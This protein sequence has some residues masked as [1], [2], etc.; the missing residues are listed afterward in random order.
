MFFECMRKEVVIGGGYI[1]VGEY[2]LGW[3]GII[4][5]VEGGKKGGR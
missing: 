3:K 2:I 5:Q 4:Y 1:V